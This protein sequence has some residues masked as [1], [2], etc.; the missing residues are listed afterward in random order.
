MT[1]RWDR[2]FSVS[3]RKHVAEALASYFEAEWRNGQFR[4]LLPKKYQTA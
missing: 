2:M 1:D 3:D 4:N